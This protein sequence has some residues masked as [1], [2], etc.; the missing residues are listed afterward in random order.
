MRIGHAKIHEGAS[1]T[2]I[3]NKSTRSTTWVELLLEVTAYWPCENTRSLQ[4]SD[5]KVIFLISLTEK[6]FIAP[7]TWY[8]KNDPVDKENNLFVLKV[9][10]QFW[11]IEK[12]RL[13]FY[14]APTLH[15]LTLDRALR[16]AAMVIPP[17]MAPYNST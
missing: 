7:L 6:K 5:N 12:F 2:T 14:A 15:R 1:I 9:I 4:P 8:N 17:K 10:L 13:S 11:S 3:D 16:P